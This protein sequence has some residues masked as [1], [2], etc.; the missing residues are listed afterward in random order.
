[1]S[2]SNGALTVLEKIS[3]LVSQLSS[4]LTS[5]T[6]LFKTSSENK[7]SDSPTNQSEEQV[8]GEYTDDEFADKVE[9]EGGIFGA[10]EYGLRATDLQDP[11]SALGQ[12][13]A[14]LTVRFEELKPLIDEVQARL[15]ESW[16][17]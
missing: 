5:L 13:W 14:E 2:G 4:I 6:K 7:T 11:T 17:Y 1:M 10:L 12:A 15:D 16:E 3:K 8:T 9:Y